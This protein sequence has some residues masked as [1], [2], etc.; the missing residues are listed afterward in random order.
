MFAGVAGDEIG[1]AGRLIG[2]LIRLGAVADGRERI[3]C[4][5]AG[6]NRRGKAKQDGM[7]RDRIDRNPTQNPFIA[8]P[9]FASL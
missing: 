7:E 5:L 2:S 8:Q 9:H 1:P 4:G 3:E 6:A